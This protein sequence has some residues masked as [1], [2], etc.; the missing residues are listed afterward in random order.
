MKDFV[1][2]DG[3][4]VLPDGRIN[5]RVR[6]EGEYQGKP[7]TYIDPLGCEGSQYIWPA[8]EEGNIDPSSFWWSEGNM[9]CDCNRRMFL[10]PEVEATVPDGCGHKIRINHIVPLDSRLPEFEPYNEDFR[11]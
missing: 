7:F 9:A 6:I 4:R 8:D 3:D 5:C 11:R 2:L 10:P 1:P